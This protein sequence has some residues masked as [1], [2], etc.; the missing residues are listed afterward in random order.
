M[1]WPGS[2]AGSVW[3]SRW[4][5]SWSASWACRVGLV[6][7]E[8]LPAAAPPRPAAGP[9]G[10]WP[11]Y[12]PWGQPISGRELQ[13]LS[14]ARAILAGRPVLLL[15]EPTRDLDAATADAVLQAVP[16]RTTDRSLPW[17]T[18]RPEELAAFAG[19]R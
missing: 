17:I 5:C 9:A 7:R 11:R 19:V 18:H 4:T 15:D 10:P 2:R 14:V 8:R 13:C 1:M 6:D 3:E 16:E 12:S